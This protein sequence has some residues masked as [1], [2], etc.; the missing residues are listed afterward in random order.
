MSAYL[1]A[2]LDIQDPNLAAEYR[3]Q[4]TP[5]VAK[6]GGTYMVRGGDVRTLEG[7]WAPGRLVI[8]EFPSMAAAQAFYDDPAYGPVMALRQRS[9]SGSVVLVEGMQG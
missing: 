4:V 1:I 5:L 6:H 9:A 2:D 3:R 8:I 7:D